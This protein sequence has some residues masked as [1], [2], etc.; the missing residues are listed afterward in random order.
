MTFRGVDSAVGKKAY[1]PKRQTAPLISWNILP[2][3]GSSGVLALVLWVTFIGQD[4]G[5]EVCG[6]GSEGFWELDLLVDWIAVGNRARHR[7]QS[8]LSGH[9]HK[10][11]T[12]LQQ[13]QIQYQWYCLMQCTLINY[14]KYVKYWEDL[15]LWNDKHATESCSV[16]NI[17][18]IRCDYFKG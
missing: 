2:F 7:S 13:C 6:S 9:G 4:N 1:F 17:G 16:T 8:A 5:G 18:S 11:Y 14:T 12:Q 15:L 10:A 3:N